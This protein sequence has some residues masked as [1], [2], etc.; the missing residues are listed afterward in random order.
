VAAFADGIAVEGL[1]VSGGKVTLAFQFTTIHVGLPFD[2]V[3]ET[4]PLSLQTPQGASQGRAQTPGKVMVKLARSRAPMVAIRGGKDRPLKLPYSSVD[5]TTDASLLTGDFVV[6][7]EPV[8]QNETTALIRHRI[9]PLTV[10]A[11][12]VDVQVT[13]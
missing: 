9:A 12:Y 6:D 8:V 11:I 7:V 2:A 13:R 4:M 1:V 10:T 5:Q 3:A